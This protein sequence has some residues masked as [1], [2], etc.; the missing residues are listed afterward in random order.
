MKLKICKIIFIILLIA[1]I[2][3]LG[4]II[5]KYGRNQINEKETQEIVDAFRNIDFPDTVAENE[6][7]QN[8]IVEGEITN[9]EKAM[10]LEYKGYKVIGIVNIDKIGIEYPIL[11]IENI[12]PETA[13]VPLQYSIIKYWGNDVNDY[14][15]LS[16][17]GHNY[18]DGTMFGKIK[19]LEIGDIIELT[20]LTGKTVQYSVYDIFSTEPNDVSILLPE[21][22]NSRE[23]T[24][25]TCTNGNKKRLI[26][27]AREI[28]NI[29]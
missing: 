8:G 24:L 9:T 22:E 18:I 16:I 29:Q 25:I 5:F 6:I 7:N 4:L 23:V 15:N 26:V 21:E 27:K 12:D 11:E 10:P 13:K 1:A 19:K 14:G 28:S 2:I 17:A 3:V 20:D